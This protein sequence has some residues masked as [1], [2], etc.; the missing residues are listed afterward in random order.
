MTTATDLAFLG[1]A[2]AAARVRTGAL[3]PQALVRTHLERIRELE[4]RVHAYVHVDRNAQSL[5]SGPLAGVT[6]AVKDTQ[7]VRGMPWTYGAAVW[8]DR[9]AT[10]DAVPVHRARLAGAAILGKVNTPELA[11]SV[12]TVN[13]LFPPTQN[14]WRS[15]I[16]PGGSSGGSAAAVA[17]GLACVAFG[18]DYGGS[19]RIPASCCGVVGLRPSV[20]R[21][22]QELPDPARLNARGPLTRSVADA[23]LLFQ[24]M[25]GEAP[26]ALTQRAR[27]VAIADANAFG[28][29]PAC[30][31]A[32]RRAAAA[33]G[34]AGYSVVDA[35]WEAAPVVAQAYRTVRRVSLA[36]LP[37]EPDDFG[38]G[39]RMLIQE[40]RAIT[41]RDYY[42]AH[43]RATSAARALVDLVTDAVD[44]ILTPTLGDLPMPIAEVPTFLGP[45][46]DR[47][48]AFV[49]PVSFAG[50]PAV[51]I[52]A[53]LHDGLPVGVQLIGRERGEWDL[54]ALAEELEAAEG[55]G[56]Q[57]PAA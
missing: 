15:G 55:F 31:D 33:L 28:V 23:R 5:A 19:I 47:Y 51:S 14:P 4:P 2:E 50:L 38:A 46:W 34:R 48:T 18:D 43:Q 42:L 40:G 35:P 22:P 10:D 16:T 25:V 6:L 20:G 30:R 12:G 9:I 21:V 49:L 39:L 36:A 41:A 24:V 54:L 45:G 52:P 7:P 8:R 29:A 27:R 3:D 1:A 13:A 37:A 53:G 26:P 57:R 17:A 11:A 56:F 44:A 32:C